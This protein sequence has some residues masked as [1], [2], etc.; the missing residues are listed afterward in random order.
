MAGRRRGDGR[1]AT[2]VPSDAGRRVSSPSVERR[3]PA[4]AAQASATLTG[5]A[6]TGVRS[7]TIEN[8]TAAALGLPAPSCATPAAMSTVSGRRGHARRRRR[9]GGPAGPAVA[10]RL[11]EEA[12]RAQR[13][14]VRRF[15]EVC[16]RTRTPA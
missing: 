9:R 3:R 8:C 15:V 12:P 10:D 4:T 1:D 14:L 6:G 16:R 7:A 11:C 2:A 5:R 13:D